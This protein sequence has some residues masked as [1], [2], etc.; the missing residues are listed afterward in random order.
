MANDDR[1]TELGFRVTGK[2]WVPSIKAIAAATQGH[3]PPPGPA[4]APAPPPVTPQKRRIGGRYAPLAPLPGPLSFGSPATLRGVLG[5]LLAPPPLRLGSPA[6]KR[7]RDPGGAAR[8]AHRRRAPRVQHRVIHPVAPP[9]APAA[10]PAAAPRGRQ[11]VRHRGRPP[12][13]HAP[14]P[15]APRRNVHHVAPHLR[16]LVASQQKHFKGIYRHDNI[17]PKL[18]LRTLAPGHFLVRAPKLT[19]GV[20]QHIISLLKRAP[21]ALWVNGHKHNKKQAL[22]VIMRLL[23]Q[24]HTVDIQLSKI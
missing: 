24:N 2:G 13:A 6:P 15:T 17:T 14:R 18:S 10:P 4:P 8:S 9:R 21:K 20:R 19:A 12:R 16:T 3:V 7:R 5:G 1:K 23:E 22:G 11:R